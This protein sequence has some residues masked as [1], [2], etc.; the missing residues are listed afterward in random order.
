[1][2]SCVTRR[3]TVYATLTVLLALLGF[4]PE[5]WS[6][7][8]YSVGAGVSL[9]GGLDNNLQPTLPLPTSDAAKRSHFYSIY[10]AVSLDSSGG[11]SVFSANYAF[12]WHRTDRDVSG[13]SSSHV[14]SLNFSRQVGARS[15]VVF[16]DSYSLTSDIQ[17]F[18]AL[19]G[20]QQTPE[21]LVF[22]FSPLTTNQSY[23]TNVAAASFSHGFSER[24]TLSISGQHS[25]RFY[26]TAGFNNSLSDQHTI[27]GTVGYSRRLSER[28]SW[29]LSGTSSH[30][31]FDN[32]NNALTNV[33]RS[34]FTYVLGRNTQ[35]SF[36]AG[37]SYVRNLTTAETQLNYELVASVQHKI[38][39]NSFSFQFS[40]DNGST[41]VGSISRTDQ[42]TVVFSRNLGRRVN[43]SFDATAF[44]SAG[45]LD[46]S[47]DSRGVYSS[48][49]V[50]VNLAKRLS[51]H[52]GVQ[53]QRYM[54][55]NPYELTQKR[56]FVSLHYSHPNLLRF[57]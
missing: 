4:S 34:G 19:G 36:T 8:V 13:E 43:V 35:G 27:S 29:I 37:P 3:L 55:P 47:V 14:A 40:H 10:P 15:S 11:H 26:D 20:V 46:N 18:Y 9:V 16:S 38:K 12:G 51:L 28:L 41:G 53:F 17:T 25:L 32:F 57:R 42:A 21:E 30:Y 39:E 24:S 49:N 23:T 5:A 44:D 6:Q 50:G 54:K 45:I 56:V 33:V 1:M 48:G 52:G 7:R 2:R 31:N 22:V